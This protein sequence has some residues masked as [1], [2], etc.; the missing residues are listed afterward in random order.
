[1]HAQLGT[2][3]EPWYTQ[4]MAWF[5]DQGV[6]I[7]YSSLEQT[8]YQY[9]PSVGYYEPLVV[10]ELKRYVTTWAD[11]YWVDGKTTESVIA[12][13]VTRLKIELLCK[14]PFDNAPTIENCK[15]GILQ[16]DS[17]VLEP[18]SPDVWSKKQIPR[19]YAEPHPLAK[20]FVH[21]I[22][23]RVC[24][25][26]K[27]G[28]RIKHFLVKM[29]RKD[30]T[31]ELFF[32]AYGIRGGGKSTM[33]GMAREMFGPSLT[34]STPIH[35]LGKR[36]GLSE[37]WD[38]RVCVNPD[39]P[40]KRLAADTVASIKLLT[41]G[42]QGSDGRI[43]VECK[44]RDSFT[45]PIQCFLLYATN[46][47]ADF[48]EDVVGE[49]E[50]IM[51]RAV[52]VH[53]TEPQKPDPDFKMLLTEPDFLDD[54]YWILL[55]EPNVSIKGDQEEFI[56]KNTQEWLR[57]ANP[58]LRILDDFL[59]FVDDER[60]GVTCK[61]VLDKVIAAYDDEAIKAPANIQQEITFALRSMR[62]YRNDVARTRGKQVAK[63]LRCKWKNPDD[64]EELDT[65]M[66]GK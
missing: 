14:E 43:E 20:L 57:D 56:E 24:S 8:F 2:E 27:N 60:K 29:V 30:H 37:I 64:E 25:T 52:M 63:Y 13:A 39:L 45:V 21:R 55:H 3:E 12:H 33:L 28:Q 41:G 19:S 15:N 11:L 65:F 59:Q 49:I 38:K 40:V 36:F 1:M 62:I 66:G 16:L 23:D 46:Q 7:K 32:I 61:K 53:Y 34:C 35:K 58:L 22:L 44:G 48:T 47:L 50:S 26:P 31:E 5:H 4:F 54:L 6:Y 18:H 42:D 10:E 9:N 17:L 51:R